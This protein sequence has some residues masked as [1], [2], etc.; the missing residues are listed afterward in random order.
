MQKFAFAC[1]LVLATLSG[2]AQT[3]CTSS[4]TVT[5]ST[6]MWGVE[7]GWTLQD[8]EGLVVASGGNAPD[9]FTMTTEVCSASPC[10]VLVMQDSFGDGWNGGSLTL[11]GPDGTSYGPYALETGSIGFATVGTGACPAFVPGCTDATAYNYNPEATWEDGSCVLPPSCGAGM[12]LVLLTPDGLDPWSSLGLSVT[13]PEGEWVP[14][15]GTQMPGNSVSNWV[16]VGPGCYTYSVW[17]AWGEE[18]VGALTWDGG[19]LP[20]ALDP[21]SGSALVGL[22][23]FSDSAD[24]TPQ[25]WGCTDA[26][27]SNYQPT[28]TSDDGSCIFPVD[29]GDGELVHFY[30]CTFNQGEEVAFTLL[31]ATTGDTLYAQTGFNTFAIVHQDL[32]VP[33]GACLTAILENVGP[34]TGWYGGYVTLT[35]ATT[36]YYG[37]LADGVESATETGLLGSSCGEDATGGTAFSWPEPIGLTAWPN[38]TEE[39]VN[40]VGEGFDAHFPVDIAVYDALG[41]KVFSAQRNPEALGSFD[42][43]E[44]TAGVYRLVCRQQDRSAGTTLI[45]R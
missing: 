10:F 25:M 3:P 27:A 17:G 35:S 14:V 32:C 1:A 24:C 43:S 45:R 8:A 6:G 36:N 23:V 9:N 41:R 40:V 20:I 44:W 37:T 13:G 16:C 15:S 29:C 26:A 30:L 38:P 5:L 11:T 21:M 7:V 19:S 22:D 18:V 2:V 34:G 31:D 4:W 28:A 33:A 42:A 39:I 12:S